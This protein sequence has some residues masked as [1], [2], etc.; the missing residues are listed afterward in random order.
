MIRLI[1]MAILLYF[2]TLNIAY[3]DHCT[4]MKLILKSDS[5]IFLVKR[6]VDLF[7]FKGE[8]PLPLVKGGVH[9]FIFIKGRGDSSR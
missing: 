4:V 7:L 5:L 8:F 9:Q 3:E 6:E 1:V 2:L